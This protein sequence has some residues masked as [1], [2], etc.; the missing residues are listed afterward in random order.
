MKS[1]TLYF[2]C[3]KMAAGKSTLAKELAARGDAILFSEDEFLATL[4][5]GEIVDVPTYITRSRRL[6]EALAEHIQT[7]LSRGIDVVLDF[8]ANTRGQRAWFRSLISASAAPHELHF[9]DATD[10]LCKAQLRIRSA[11]N[12]GEAWTSDAEFDAVT[13]YFEPPSADEGFVVISH[14]RG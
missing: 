14:A 11:P 12:A 7:L 3:G 8:P 5:P 4:F 2:L 1:G 6:R 10:D 9:I 13:A